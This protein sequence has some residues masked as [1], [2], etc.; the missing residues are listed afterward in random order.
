MTAASP[1]QGCAWVTGA[2]GGIGAAVALRLAAAGWTVAASARRM[3]QLQEVAAL[4]T[5]GAIVPTPLT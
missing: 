2:S 4:A 5:G 3:A 1:A